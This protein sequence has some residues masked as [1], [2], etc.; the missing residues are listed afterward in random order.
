MSFRRSE[1]SSFVRNG[2]HR[3][4]PSDQITSSL[5]ATIHF[6]SSRIRLMRLQC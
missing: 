5:S 3:P 4:V 6:L 2:G 1:G